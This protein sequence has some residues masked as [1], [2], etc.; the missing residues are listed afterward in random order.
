[1]NDDRSPT[2]TGSVENASKL[3]S[4]ISKKTIGIMTEQDFKD[5]LSFI[6]KVVNDC[7]SLT[8]E[9]SNMAKKKEEL[10]KRV[11][12]LTD[13]N[14]EQQTQLG[15][16]IEE[17]KKHL[18]T[19]TR[20]AEERAAYLEQIDLLK[21]QRDEHKENVLTLEGIAQ[22][23]EDIR[24]EQ[25]CTI[26]GLRREA[27]S[28]ASALNTA[29]PAALMVGTTKPKKSV[30]LPDPPEFTG[31]EKLAVEDWLIMMRNKL[32]ANADLYDTETIRMAYVQRLVGGKA[33]SHLRP[34]VMK[35][36]KNPFRSADEMMDLLE[37]RYKDPNRQNTALNA[38]RNLYQNKSSFREFWAE[39]LSLT[40]ELDM[41]NDT[42]I[43]ELR[44]RMDGDMARHLVTVEGIKTVY[45]LARKCQLYEDNMK[46]IRPRR[47]ANST[48]AATGKNGNTTTSGSGS[49]RPTPPT[50]TES[51]AGAPARRTDSPYTYAE[52]QVMM[53]E[54]KCFKCGEKGHI[55]AN[56]PKN[57]PDARLD[58][59]AA[60]LPAENGELLEKSLREC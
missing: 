2:P 25:A 48:P 18:A 33:A 23:N 52:R 15:S 34:R 41:T 5:G 45:D 19:I 59:R 44:N 10:S 42:L 37:E 8:T 20:F 30:K 14:M 12:R 55:R 35:N 28:A 54:G 32:T 16:L 46:I 49:G 3:W 53:T 7:N 38:F 51:N 11:S 31:D 36:T 9:Y 58:V 17:R 26:E 57:M 1:M 27:Q 29:S 60:D 24:M 50:K 47:D 56:C 40:A 43:Y 21:T 4:Q 39:F 22:E 13:E 6:N